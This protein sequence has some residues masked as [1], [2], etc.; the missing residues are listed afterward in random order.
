MATHIQQRRLWNEDYDRKK[1]SRGGG[2]WP[3]WNK[4]GKELIFHALGSGNFVAALLTAP[5]DGSGPAFQVLSPPQ[6]IIRTPLMNLPH[7]GGDYHTYAVH[8]KQPDRFLV[9]AFVVPDALAAG[10][11]PGPDP[12]ATL[13]V[14]MNWASSLPR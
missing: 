4:N 3:R 8:P 11:F 14:A 13:V 6:E 10:T 9:Y 1:I 7:T 12:G 2:D 5:V